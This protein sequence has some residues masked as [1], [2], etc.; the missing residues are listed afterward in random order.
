MIRLVLSAAIL[1]GGA[2]RRLD[3]CDK[4]ALLVEGRP[5]LDRQVDELAR[6]ARDILLVGR[7]IG[8]GD[9]LERTGGVSV[10]AVPDRRPGHGPLGGLDAALAGARHEVLIVVACDMP[11]VSAALLEHLAAL[12]GGVDAVVPQTASGCHPLCAAYTRACRAPVARRLAAGRLAMHGLLGDLRVRLVTD[13]EIE[14]FGDPR[15][16]LA[17]INTAGDYAQLRGE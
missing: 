17:N 7:R 3:G 5:I 15:R 14:A 8:A 10:R 2:A 13:K 4:G 11:F 6:I 1:R 12:A 16:L 9:C